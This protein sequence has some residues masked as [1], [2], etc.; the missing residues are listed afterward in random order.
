MAIREAK[1]DVVPP[2]EFLEELEGLRRAYLKGDVLRPRRR[3]KSIEEAAAGRRRFHVGGRGHNHKFEGERYLNCTDRDVRRR[4]LRKL[5]DEEGE[6]TVGGP[7]P[8]H[9]ILMRRESHAFGVTD[10]EI[11]RLEKE[12]TT[13]DEFVWMGW[14]TA[15]H[16]EAHW[17]VAIGSSLV[18]EGEKRIPE[19]RQKLL[20]DIEA[21]RAEYTA[22]GV[23]DLDGALGNLIE[24]AAVDEDHSEFGAEVTRRFVNTPE[25]QDELREAFILTMQ[26]R[27]F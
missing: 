12:D 7:K 18:G 9:P 13:P 21:L 1:P 24:H 15:M 22:M 27:G 16:R 6:T 25:L 2:E 11:D 10:A 4:Q 5:I 26:L 23:E 17:A 8:P 3:Y 14:R 20:D 19:I